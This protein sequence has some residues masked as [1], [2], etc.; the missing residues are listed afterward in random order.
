MIRLTND[1]RD[2]N[3][4]I[5]AG[6]DAELDRIEPTV[7]M[8]LPGCSVLSLGEL[9]TLISQA[10]DREFELQPTEPAVAQAA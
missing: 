10:L 5:C 8:F 2:I 1:L 4:L 9:E 6:L 7:S 3:D